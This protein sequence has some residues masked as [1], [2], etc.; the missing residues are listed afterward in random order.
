LPCRLVTFSGQRDLPEQVAS[1][2][3]L[4]LLVGQPEEL[5]V[6][7]DG[8]HTAAAVALLR[9]LHPRLQVFPW[10]QLA[11]DPLPEPLPRHAALHP[12]GKK[13]ALLLGQS[14]SASGQRPLVY[15]DS[16]ILF[17]PAAAADFPAWLQPRPGLAGRFLLDCQPALDARLLRPEDSTEIPLNSGLLILHEPPDWQLALSRLRQLWQQAPQADADHYTEQTALHLALPVPRYRPLPHHSCVVNIL[18]QFRHED[19]FRDEPR[20]VLRHYVN[21]VRYKFWRAVPALLG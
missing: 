5:V 1:L 11:P 8:S 10:P 19:L 16:D 15:A 12:L 7:S 13:L 2:L 4:L 6:G 3:S 21:L 17:F 14:A 20:L 9:E 18:D